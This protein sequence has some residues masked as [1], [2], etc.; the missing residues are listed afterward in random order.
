[1]RT[2]HRESMIREVQRA[3]FQAAI[4]ETYPSGE[5]FTLKDKLKFCEHAIRLHQ[6]FLYGTEEEVKLQYLLTLAID[7]RIIMLLEKHC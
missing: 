3:S 2:P 4:R 5:K 7:L 1:M 6:K